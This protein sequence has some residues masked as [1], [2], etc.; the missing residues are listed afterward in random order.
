MGFGTLPDGLG[1]NRISQGRGQ[2][3]AATGVSR[4]AANGAAGGSYFSVS[5]SGE[6]TFRFTGPV[7]IAGSL[8]GEIETDGP[9]II[10]AG[11][12]LSGRVTAESIIVYGKLKGDVRASERVE[13]W[14]D[15]HL[16][17]DVTAPSIR[18]DPQAIVTADLHIAPPAGMPAKDTPT[19]RA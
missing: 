5:C 4:L 7:H 17:G 3:V 9:L 18:I 8:K 12:E 6:G 10:E 13:V 16:E 1:Y 14:P 15:A 2:A 19:A 11:G